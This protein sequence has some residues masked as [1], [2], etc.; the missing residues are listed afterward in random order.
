MTN[1][2]FLFNFKKYLT[3][4]NLQKLYNDQIF[5]TIQSLI[6]NAINIGGIGLA[7][8]IF[9]ATAVLRSL[10][11]SLD[12]IFKV[13]HQRS[14]ILKIIYYWAALTLGPLMLFVG[15]TLATQLSATLSPADYNETLFRGS[16]TWTVGS[17][18]SAGIKSG[19]DSK[20]VEINNDSIDF[21][22]QIVYSFE[23][24]S[25][26]MIRDMET[27]IEPIDFSKVTFNDIVVNGPFIKIVGDKGV[28]ISS[29]NGGQNWDLIKLAN[30]TINDIHM[31][32]K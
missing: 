21:E 2:S 17:K 7:V 26:E 10:E 23:S 14:I 24:D 15:T 11:Q 13:T 29:N 28:L 32:S 18:A 20:L 25:N 8:L 22:N 4:Y 5:E 30:F 12:K 3:E 27:T 31:L 1:N 6:D 16:Q 19:V 9:S